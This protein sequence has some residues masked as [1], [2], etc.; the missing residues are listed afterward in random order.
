MANLEGHIIVPVNQK[1]DDEANTTRATTCFGLPGYGGIPASMSSCHFDVHVA[2]Y[3]SNNVYL[4]LDGCIMDPVVPETYPVR[5]TAN[6]KDWNWR[7]SGGQL[8]GPSGD[9]NW[10]ANINANDGSAAASPPAGYWGHGETA[11]Q[12]AT[13]AGGAA[14]GWFVWE[15]SCSDPPQTAS[16]TPAGY[17]YCGKLTEFEASD[18]GDDGFIYLGGTGTYSVNDPIYPNPVKIKVPGFMRYLDY[19]P[20]AIRKSSKW[21]SCNRSGGSLTIRKSGSWR[22]VKNVEIGEGSNDA[23]YRSGTNWKVAPK[24]GAE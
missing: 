16:G 11:A 7:Y 3:D 23:Y 15:F 22:D 17:R 13:Q 20:W 10:T 2:I 1:G 12:A 19:Y 24:I 8:V 4:G 14:Q 9:A 5:L 6:A 18:T 21:M